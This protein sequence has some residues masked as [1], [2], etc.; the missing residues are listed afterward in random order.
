MCLLSENNS[1][2]LTYAIVNNIRTKSVNAVALQY[3]VLSK[4]FRTAAA[5]CWKPYLW[6]NGHHHPW[7]SFHPHVQTSPSI[8]ATGQMFSGSPVLWG[9]LA[10]PGMLLESSLECRTDGLSTSFSFGDTS[11]S[12]GARSGDYVRWGTTAMLVFA[13]KV[14]VS[15]DVWQGVLK[16]CSSQFPWCQSLDH[17]HHTFSWSCCKTTQ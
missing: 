8:S 15:T 7:S 14:L 11:M 12:Q 5:I 3:E 10:L 13:K 4:I 2:P 17:H 1:P 9:C 6:T 16:W